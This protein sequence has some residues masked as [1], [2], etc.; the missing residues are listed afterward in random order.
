[1]NDA[2]SRKAPFELSVERFIAAPPETVFKVWTGRRE[3]WWCPKPWTTEVIEQDLRPGG[4]LAMVMRGPA[5]LH[6]RPSW[7]DSSSSRP[8][9]P[10]HATAPAPAI[11]TRPRISSMSKW[12]SWRVGERSPISWRNSPRYGASLNP[13]CTT[14]APS[15]FI[16]QH[17]T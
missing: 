6:R 10:G 17:A 2:T 12:D 14:H 7:S 9:E 15:Q 1:M 16:A 11:G 4:R 13:A 8:K 3:E 5:G